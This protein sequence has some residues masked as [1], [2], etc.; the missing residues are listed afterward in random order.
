MQLIDDL[1]SRLETEESYFRSALLREDIA[2]LGRLRATALATASLEAFMKDAVYSG[3]SANDLRT[4]ELRPALEPFLAAFYE[5]ARDSA[6]PAHDALN[7]LWADFDRLRMD[8]LVGC[9]SRVPGI[10]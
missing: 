5:A 10:D 3:W 9:L 6:S 4:H 1:S 7:A 8:R 2:R